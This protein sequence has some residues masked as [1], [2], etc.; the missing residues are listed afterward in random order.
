MRKCT[1]I[2][3]ILSYLPLFLILQ[4]IYFQEFAAVMR[5]R[6]GQFN[7]NEAAPPKP[8]SRPYSE[9]F[10]PNEPAPPRPLTRPHSVYRIDT[11]QQHNKPRKNLY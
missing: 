2:P 5:R 7:P 3:R 9:Q 6:S 1:F 10:N 11:A 4:V 8:M